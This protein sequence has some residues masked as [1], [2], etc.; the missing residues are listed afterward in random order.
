MSWPRDLR[1][2]QLGDRDGRLRP[3]PLGEIAHVASPLAPAGATRD[4]RAAYRALIDAVFTAPGASE[5]L[6][7]LRRAVAAV[8]AGKDSAP[9]SQVARDAIR[10]ADPAGGLL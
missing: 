8:L 1:L 10:P 3:A 9:R 5:W 6:A 7:G 2:E 4:F